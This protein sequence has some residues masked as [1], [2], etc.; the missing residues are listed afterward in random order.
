MMK[1][2]S[3][4]Q[5]FRVHMSNYVPKS[6]WTTEAEACCAFLNNV[7]KKPLQCPPGQTPLISLPVHSA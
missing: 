1:I 5:A 4:I 6:N 3:V 7:R 2:H